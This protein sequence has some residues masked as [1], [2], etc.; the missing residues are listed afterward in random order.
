MSNQRNTNREAASAASLTHEHTSMNNLASFPDQWHAP[1]ASLF[2][3]DTEYMRATIK[4]TG[5][6]SA[7]IGE[8][9]GQTRRIISYYLQG[10]KQWSYPVQYA[11]ESL[12][13]IG[14]PN[15]PVFSF[16]DIPVIATPATASIPTPSRALGTKWYRSDERELG[17]GD[18][19]KLVVAR[20]RYGETIVGKVVHDGFGLCVRSEGMTPRSFRVSD[21]EV[22]TLLDAPNR[23]AVE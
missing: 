9:V 21:V 2:R 13:G 1:D 23:G 12:R 14:I 19:G 20:D 8:R 22:F 18:E 16:S 7:E 4:A 3:T 5:L 11:I 6:S 10:E 17:T 15:D